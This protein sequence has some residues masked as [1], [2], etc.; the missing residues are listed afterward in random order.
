M[1]GIHGTLS[2][3]LI[4]HLTTLSSAARLITYHCPVTTDVST[5]VFIHCLILHGTRPRAGVV[6][7]PLSLCCSLVLTTLGRC[8]LRHRDM[9]TPI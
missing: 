9:Y 3:K 1:D 2:I 7:A 4:I 5:Y 8:K 6:H